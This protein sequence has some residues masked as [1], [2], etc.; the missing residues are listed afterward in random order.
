MSVQAATFIDAL[1]W[2]AR[3]VNQHRAGKGELLDLKCLEALQQPR[4]SL[5][6]NVVIFWARLPGKII[7]GSKMHNRGE[8]L[9]I[10]FPHI[11]ERLPY[12]FLRREIH[13]HAIYIR[14]RVWD[15]GLTIEPNN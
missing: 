10:A 1:T 12:T 2:L 7:I 8:R 11:R 4:S 15:G 5:H 13:R 3:R 9:P 6:R 14:R